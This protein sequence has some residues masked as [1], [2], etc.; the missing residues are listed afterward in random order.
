MERVWR[1]KLETSAQ[2]VG[3]IWYIK[4]VW[5]LFVFIH[6]YLYIHMFVS[7]CFYMYIHIYIYYLFTNGFTYIYIHTVWRGWQ[8][9]KANAKANNP[10]CRIH[11]WIMI[12]NSRHMPD[13][14]DSHAMMPCS[15]FPQDKSANHFPVFGQCYSRSFWFSWLVI[16]AHS[17][18]GVAQWK[19]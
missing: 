3:T 17:P 6:R 1:K 8:Y 13:I 9:A 11:K 19:N 10:T 14:S 15:T 7:I 16:D 4:L 12:S 5:I 18:A 2:P